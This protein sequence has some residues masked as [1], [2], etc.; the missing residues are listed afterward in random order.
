MK[1]TGDYLDRFYETYRPVKR[2]GL[3]IQRIVW[4]LIMLSLFAASGAVIGFA[5]GIK[6]TMDY[7]KLKQFEFYG[8]RVQMHDKNDKVVKTFYEQNTTTYKTIDTLDWRNLEMF[9]YSEDRRFYEH[10]GIDVRGI[11]RALAV[12]TKSGSSSQGASTITQQ[13]IR[14]Q[15]LTTEKTYRRKIDEMLLAKHM[16]IYTEK[17]KILEM[18]MNTVYF[19]YNNYGVESAS[20]FYWGKSFNDLSLSQLASLIPIVQAPNAFNPINNLERNNEKREIVLRSLKQGDII[21]EQEY[22]K[23]LLDESYAA[24]VSSKES[25][26]E[27]VTQVNSYYLETAYEQVV[28]DLRDKYQISREDAIA[29]L[30]NGGY[31]IKTYY[32]QDLD[33]YL[34]SLAEERR[35]ALDDKVQTAIV[36]LDS[37]GNPKGILGGYNKKEGN[38]VFNRATQATRSPGSTFKTL[39]SYAPA[40]MYGDYTANSSVTDAKVTYRTP[41]G[42]YTPHNYN[43]RY[44]GTTTIKN[45]LAQSINSVAVGLL[46][47][48]GIDRAFELVKD[49]GITTLVENRNGY[50]DKGLSMALG[51]LTDGVLPIDMATAY[52]TVKTGIHT[53]PLFYKEV[54]DGNDT[55]ILSGIN[56][57]KQVL[58]SEVSRELTESLKAVVETGTGRRANVPGSGFV[59][60][61]GTTSDTKDLWF[62]GYTPEDTVAVWYGY[63]TPKPMKSNSNHLLLARDV[64]TYLE[65]G[66]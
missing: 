49:L 43:N 38:L 10:K 64:V 7:T 16:E 35:H 45:A 53:E 30:Q 60:K 57:R 59:G 32:D 2:G 42:P 14:S 11:T 4:A 25:Y 55:V 39:A 20:Q 31:K 48:V 6:D 63:D 37:K 65:R 47:E 36:V 12:N 34:T 44:I 21:S 18:Y 22:E 33:K 61:T 54:V 9:V 46:S 5:T 66:K 40:M 27:Q 28:R 17:D 3:W 51:G 24:L 8:E 13:L 15:V 1:F 56:V 26:N 23:A 50:T 29:K 41:S 19:G 62:V 52:H 58:R